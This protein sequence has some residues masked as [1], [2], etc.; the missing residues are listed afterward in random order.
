M[1]EKP[2][3]T[4]HSPDE[5]NVSPLR[6]NWVWFSLQAMAQVVFTLMFRARTRGVENLPTEG[7]ALLLL[8]HQSFLDPLVT[9]VWL[10]RPV[11][12]LARD[13]LFRVPIVGW[14]LR[15]TYVMPIN[16]SSGSSAVIRESVRRLEQGFLLGIFSEGTRSADGQLGRL[17]PG[18]LAVIRRTDVPVIPVGI[19]GTDK[20]LG[21]NHWFPRP[22]RVRVVIGEPIPPEQIEKLSEKGHEREMLELVRQRILDC[23]QAA[24]EWPPK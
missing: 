18:F 9:G 19:A 13:S 15:N 17:K 24:V 7:G 4:T 10:K 12:Y 6:R 11:S 23:R 14:I 21:R 3:N 2:S 20:A 16:R 22:R 8:N 1:S 5:K